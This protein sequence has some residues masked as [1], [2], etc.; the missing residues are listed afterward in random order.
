VGNLAAI[1]LPPYLETA[2]YRFGP[3]L[4]FP[5]VLPNTLVDSAATTPMNNYALGAN[6]VLRLTWNTTATRVLTGVVPQFDGQILAVW[7]DCVLGRD[8]L[9][10]MGDSRSSVGN[11]FQ[12]TAQGT[13]YLPGFGI[14]IGGA[15]LPIPQGTQQLFQYSLSENSWIAIGAPTLHGWTD[16]FIAAAG[17]FFRSLGQP[18][19]SFGW[20]SHDM[21]GTNNL[22]TFTS[23]G[24]VDMPNTTS[25]G[26]LRLQSSATGGGFAGLSPGD[27][28][29]GDAV[30][31]ANAQASPWFVYGRI[32][33]D[34]LTANT[35]VFCGTDTPAHNNRSGLLLLGTGAATGTLQLNA[36]GVLTATSFALDIPGWHEYIVTYDGTTM[37]AMVDSL[38]VG[39]A[40]NSA[41]VGAV[42]VGVDVFCFN[43]NAASNEICR[44]DRFAAAY[45]VAP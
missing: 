31:V 41:S 36:N 29:L 16:K 27:G 23:V 45:P 25:G 22:H 2:G 15:F 43:N 33:L 4:T 30:V 3:G 39:N 28:A 44:V 24:T 6:T 34:T 13:A 20:T 5:V 32:K 1:F 7:N 37:S 19:G 35:R 21:L 8:V 17:A 12:A 26:V 38:D 10:S 14:G 42:S 11:R 40:A 9:V 18:A